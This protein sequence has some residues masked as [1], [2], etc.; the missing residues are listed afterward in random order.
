MLSSA[1]RNAGTN[2]VT[3][4]LL[5]AESQQAAAWSWTSSLRPLPVLR[6]GYARQKLD[7]GVRQVVIVCRDLYP[8]LLPHQTHQSPAEATPPLTW[9]PLHCTGPAGY[10]V[11]RC[12]CYTV[13]APP[14][15]AAASG[16]EVHN[17]GCASGFLDVLPRSRLRAMRC[18]SHFWKKFLPL[19]KAFK[20][21]APQWQPL[22][23]P[24]TPTMTFNC[25]QDTTV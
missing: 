8:R 6:P 16:Q 20:R 1:P 22:N 12:R 7:P 21:M 11:L 5:T 9:L 14:P 24:T 10:T 13:P 15:A 2:E 18:F 4:A 23:V 19:V 3:K 17:T 25:L